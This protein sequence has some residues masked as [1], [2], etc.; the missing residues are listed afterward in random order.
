MSSSHDEYDQ[1]E[2]ADRMLY[3]DNH[4]ITAGASAYHQ[5]DPA[6]I[7]MRL[8]EF[9]PIEHAASELWALREEIFSGFIEYI[10]A[11][12]PDPGDVRMR[13]EGFL[14][15]FSP[16]LVERIKGPEQWTATE[17]ISGVLSKY[18]VKLSEVALH[19]S[20]KATLFRWNSELE[21]ESDFENVRKMLVELVKLMVSQGKHWRNLTSVAY[22]IA[23]ALRPSLIAGMSLHDIAILSGDKGGRATPQNRVKRLYNDRVAGAGFKACHVHFQK[24]SE[25]IEKYSKAQMGNHNRRKNKRKPAKK[26]KP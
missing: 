19:H 22:C 1:T 25:V 9:D 17:K 4:R 24:S 5:L 12:G 2:A 13:I 7:T 16:D 6:E 21:R 18:Q 26:T 15:S 14:K 10:F 11:D 8:E 23:K 3:R 20:E